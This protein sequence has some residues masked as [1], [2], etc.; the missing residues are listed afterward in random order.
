MNLNFWTKDQ[1]MVWFTSLITLI[2]ILAGVFE[3]L[4]YMI[5]KLILFSCIS[6]VV[7]NIYFVL[8]KEENKKSPENDSE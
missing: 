2:F 6:F 1:F 4:D 3:V 5:I 8:F 7:A